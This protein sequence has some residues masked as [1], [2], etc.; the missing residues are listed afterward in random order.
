MRWK[1]WKLKVIF[2]SKYASP[3]NFRK[4][5]KSIIGNLW[6]SLAT[7]ENYCLLKLLF[8]Y[9]KR[10]HIWVPHVLVLLKVMCPLFVICLHCAKY[11]WD[12]EHA[13]LHC[14][15]SKF[16][17]ITNL[18]PKVKGGVWKLLRETCLD[19]HNYSTST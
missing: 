13:C 9:Y 16:L 10:I 6:R 1:R 2:E 14:W 17:G 4:H 19:S 7:S 15:L 18:S 12:I 8:F 5:G 11:C 3:K